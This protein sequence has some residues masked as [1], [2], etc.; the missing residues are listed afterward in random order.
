MRTYLNSGNDIRNAEQMKTAME[1]NDGVRGLSVVLGGSLQVPEKYVPEKW[2]GVS[3]INDIV[4]KKRNME[5]WR[6]YDVGTGKKIPL[7]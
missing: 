7:H 6:A 1:S 2:D 3:L 4:Y 5:V